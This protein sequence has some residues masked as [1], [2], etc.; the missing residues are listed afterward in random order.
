MFAAHYFS[1][2]LV[3]FIF[4]KYI[5]YPNVTGYFC[6]QLYISLYSIIHFYFDI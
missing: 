3:E 1:K 6:N 5:L 2:W 4:H